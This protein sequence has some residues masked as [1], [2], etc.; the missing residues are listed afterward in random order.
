MLLGSTVHVTS[1]SA[2]QPHPR[3]PR[4][5]G[6]GTAPSSVGAALHGLHACGGA[7]ACGLSME[8]SQEH[9]V[10][11]ELPVGPLRSHFSSFHFGL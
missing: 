4:G 11:D 6:P 3:L 9:T 2:P 7:A 5:R 1:P 8:K 10:G